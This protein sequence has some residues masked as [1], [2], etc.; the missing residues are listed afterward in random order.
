METSCTHLKITSN[1]WSGRNMSTEMFLIHDRRVSKVSKTLIQALFTGYILNNWSY[2]AECP[3][4]VLELG[5]FRL[6]DTWTIFGLPVSTFLKKALAFIYPIDFHWG[7]AEWTC[8]KQKY[9]S[10]RWH[11]TSLPFWNSLVALKK[12]SS[13]FFLI[14]HISF[15]TYV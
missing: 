1:D 9:T 11:C 4:F 7:W 15:S 3:G 2:Y 5:L 12:S 14:N 10:S 8:K 6:V 13:C